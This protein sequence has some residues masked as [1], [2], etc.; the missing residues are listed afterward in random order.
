MT[1]DSYCAATPETSLLFR[2]RNA[3][4]V[5]R[6]ADLVG[7][8]LPSGG[9]LVDRLDVVLEIVGVEVLQ[10]DAPLR[11]WTVDE[12]AI[13]FQSLFQH[14]FRLVFVGG[15]GTHDVLVDAFLRRL[16]GEVR[17]VPTVVVVT[18]LLD[19]LVILLDLVFV[20]ARA[21][22]HILAHLHVG[23]GVGRLVLCHRTLP[24]FTH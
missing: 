15:D 7:Q 19:D 20:H 13:P 12:I 1:S 14:P 5:V 22:S 2:F 9:L 10:I 18:E 8:F 4:L 11:H 6:G 23:R 17:I 21:I 3:E 24:P 16:A